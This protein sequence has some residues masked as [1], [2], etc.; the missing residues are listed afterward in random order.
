M[1]QSRIWP[2]WQFLIDLQLWPLIFLQPLNLQEYTVPHLKD[3]HHIYL[4]PQIK[5]LVW[6][7]ALISEVQSYSKTSRCKKRPRIN[8]LSCT[9]ILKQGQ[10]W[11]FALFSWMQRWSKMFYQLARILFPNF[12]CIIFKFIHEKFYNRFYFPEQISVQLNKLAF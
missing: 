11:Y 10:K 7:L 12:A 2:S 9:S 8:V 4:E 1:H 3:L 6:L 5:G